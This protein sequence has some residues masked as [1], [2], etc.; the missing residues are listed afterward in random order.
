MLGHCVIPAL[1]SRLKSLKFTQGPPTIRIE[2]TIRQANGAWRPG[3]CRTIHAIEV[4]TKDE[5]ARF[6]FIKHAGGEGWGTTD[7]FLRI[8]KILKVRTDGI[9]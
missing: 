9:A 4:A 7:G 6:G 5:P 8:T 1:R 2:E 3:R